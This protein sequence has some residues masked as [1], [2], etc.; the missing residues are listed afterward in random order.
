MQDAFLSSRKEIL[1]FLNESFRAWRSE[2]SPINS[3]VD[4]SLTRLEEFSSGG[5]GL[6]GSLVVVFA[7]ALGASREQAVRV[8]AAVE[9]FQSG[10]LVHDDIMDGDL[11]RRGAASMHA[12]LAEVGGERYGLGGGICVGDVALFLSFRVLNGCTRSQELVEL[13]SREAVSVGFGQMQDVFL[14]VS[15]REPSVDEILSVYR[16]KTARYTFSLPLLLA[17]CLADREDLYGLLARFGEELGVSFQVRDDV[18]GLFGS[19]QETG[20]PVGADVREDKKTLVRFELL[21]LAQ[22]VDKEWVSSLFGRSA[23]SEELA[24]LQ[25]LASDLGVLSAVELHAS[26]AER[27]AESFLDDL[28][29]S[30]DARKVLDWLVRFN[31]ARTK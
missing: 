30:V 3:L 25:S 19:E 14:G 27:R 22:G 31:R 24:R 5:K 18:L 28:Q 7:S 16:Y 8:G 20:K 17:A 13:F 23:S 29:V 10:V 21:R 26:A 15:E 1:S 9:L 6:R 12:Q 2:F 11:T 4:D